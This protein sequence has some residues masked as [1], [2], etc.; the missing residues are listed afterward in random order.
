MRITVIT[1][2]GMVIGDSELSVER[3]TSVENHASRPEVVHARDDGAGFSTRYSSTVEREMLYVAVPFENGSGVVRAGMPLTVVNET[4]SQ[5]RRVL[6]WAGVVA[7]VVGLLA[8]ALASFAASRALHVIVD[9]TRAI[10]K[11]GSTRMDASSRDELG[12]LA[13]SINQLADD[14]Q[15]A[16]G[17]LAS[18]RDRLQAILQGMREAVVVVDD[19]NQI[20]LLNPSARKLLGV[21]T[22]SARFLTEA[23]GSAPLPQLATAGGRTPGGT[24]FQWR[25]RTLRAHASELKASRS[26]V[27][28]LHDV[29]EA[30]RLDEIRRD[31]V[32]NVSHELRTPVS[33]IR[34]NSETL[35]D[36]ALAGS[37]EQA[38]S[39]VQATLRNAERLSDLIS[40]LLDLASIEGGGY[41]MAPEPL[42]ISMVSKRVTEAL[43]E[44]AVR[45]DIDLIVDV[46]PHVLAF[47]DARAVDQVLV[48]LI[49]NAIKYTYEN[50]SIT[51]RAFAVDDQIRTEVIDQ[52]PGI[53]E[54]HRERVFE[55][56]YR[57]DVGRSRA[58][59]GTGLGLSIAKHLLSSMGGH[60]GLD[61][62]EPNGCVFW[63][64][65]PAPKAAESAA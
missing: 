20:E 55:R 13:G 22:G 32:A 24:E 1:A 34:A 5:L 7:L 65:L 52:G 9:R 4:A 3:L 51:I 53:P 12:V 59:G 50:T 62:A 6:M 10:A 27:F 15:A 31:F 48:N 46:A 21:G 11:G 44:T 36:G 64:T 38:K 2:D 29:T 56:F 43:R 61:P 63:F 37:Q 33:V 25:G 8:S 35:L 19:L 26:R 57:V 45:R 41:P 23:V 28:V 49:A 47:A 60:I 54:E 16:V 17:G 42:S 18:E 39:F 30:R 14:L 58:L 40:D